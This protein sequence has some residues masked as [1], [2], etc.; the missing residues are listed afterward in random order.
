MRRQG[1]EADSHS[2]PFLSWRKAIFDLVEYDLQAWW[3]AMRNYG[4]SLLILYVAS[5]VLQALLTMV[6]LALPIYALAVSASPFEIGLM[7][8]VGGLMYSIMARLLGGLSDRFSKK[9]F[10]ILG[11]VIQAIVSLVYPFCVGILQLISLRLIQ[12]LG[13]ALFWPATEAM[14]A[15]GAHNN[16][17]GRALVGFN[18][19]WGAANMVG[20]PLA[21]FMITAFFLTLPFY[22]SSVLG[23]LVSILLLILRDRIED[24]PQ[25][26]RVEAVAAA[27]SSNH[28]MVFLPII[29][30]FIY[31]FDGSIVGALFPVS[32]TRLNIPAFQI[33]LLFFLSS[34]IQTLVFVFSEKIIRRVRRTSFII[35]TL[36]FTVSLTLM[37]FAE[38]ATVFAPS[39]IVLGFG[40]GILYSSSLYYLLIEGG[41]NRGHV[42]GRFESTLGLAS[43][44]G[45]LVGGAIAQFGLL[46]PYAVGAIVSFIILILQ[47]LFKVI[48]VDVGG[49]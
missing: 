48:S 6:F 8:A 40:Q 12:S 36:A 30:T 18:V 44:L 31:S 38:D 22:V 20:A 47:F 13:L 49:G 45:P 29:A 3:L 34:L 37:S 46:Y 24:N 33:G 10:I 23:L 17:I 27:D 21:G 1:R 41:K 4:S 16:A 35:G 43:F 2:P 28:F 14:V 26:I 42:T 5:G 11:A 7:S 39:F 15:A 25:P 9:S 32:A 19:S